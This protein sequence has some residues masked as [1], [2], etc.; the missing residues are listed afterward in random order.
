MLR[1]S[2]V[3]SPILFLFV[4]SLLEKTV[5]K[6]R[7]KQID[8]PRIAN[9]VNS[10]DYVIR[11]K[12]W[13]IAQGLY[14]EFASLIDLTPETAL[15]QHS[16]EGSDYPIRRYDSIGS[17]SRDDQKRLQEIYT[18]ELGLPEH[19]LYD[20]YF[21]QIYH[22]QTVGGIRE[23][24]LLRKTVSL[25][26]E[27]FKI[28][29]EWQGK[30]KLD[31]KSDIVKV[32]RDFIE[33]FTTVYIKREWQG[34]VF[35][36]SL[37]VA[38][39]GILTGTVTGSLGISLVTLGGGELLK[40]VVETPVIPDSLKPFFFGTILFL[41]ICCLILIVRPKWF[42]PPDVPRP[43]SSN[44]PPLLPTSMP[45]LPSSTP[46]TQ[47]L[48][49]ITMAAPTEISI[50]PTLIP[51]ISTS[52]SSSP[53]YCLYVTQPGD[54][55][56]SI[57]SWFLIS[58][59]DFRSDNNLLPGTEYVQ[60]VMVNVRTSCCNSRFPGGYTYTVKPGDTVFS[61]AKWYHD[62]VPEYLASANNLKEPWYIQSG[63]MLCIP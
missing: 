61:I 16:S 55:A 53:N 51:V 7:E 36:K 47:L 35:D 1:D 54:T 60:R 12:A 9:L 13:Q 11:G 39:A 57:S 50:T 44:S 46:T 4:H 33:W 31:P 23:A 6:Y 24:R 63:Q 49:T 20:Q 5:E 34:L 58:E 32:S 8:D 38:V 21:S 37:E 10:P 28:V 25:E 27:T 19:P 17:L 2:R 22:A 29:A 45:L 59:N 26:D 40:A 56:Q 62:M 15:A 48:A 30:I 52:I 14:N 3:G 42:I 43:T 41:M 18:S